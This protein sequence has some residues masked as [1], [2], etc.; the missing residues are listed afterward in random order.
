MPVCDAFVGG[1]EIDPCRP[2]LCQVCERPRDEHAEAAE[3]AAAPS[4]SLVE[5]LPYER[6]DS[7]ALAKAIRL[8]RGERLLVLQPYGWHIDAHHIPNAAEHFSR[9]GV[10]EEHG[11]Q[12][13]CEFGPYVAIV[14]AVLA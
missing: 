12:V 2:H 14:K 7:T 3:S 4:V 11:W 10:C 13:V 5:T 1:F 8:S 6:I 9:K